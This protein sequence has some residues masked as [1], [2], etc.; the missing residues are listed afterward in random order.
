MIEV[1][2][3]LDNINYEQI[4]E[5]LL[6]LGLEKLKA[7]HSEGKLGTFLK[8][9]SV[10]PPQ[11]VSSMLAALPQETKDELIVMLLNTKKDSIIRTAEQYAQKKNLSVE[12][13]DAQVS[14]K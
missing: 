6:P 12:I 1:T 7:T 8:M 5:Q 4:A 3:Q 14:L 2:L 9:A 13:K 11:A 10:L